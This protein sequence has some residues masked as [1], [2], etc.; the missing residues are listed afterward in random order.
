[1]A[2]FCWKIIKITQ[3]PGGLGLHFQNLVFDTL[4]LHQFVQHASQLMQFSDKKI[5]LAAQLLSP[6]NK[7]L[8]ARLSR[9]FLLELVDILIN[10]CI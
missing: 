1:M 8:V 7:I 4:E 2:I 5:Y 3:R 9:I 6:V 10:F